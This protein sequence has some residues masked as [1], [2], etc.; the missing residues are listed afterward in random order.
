MNQQ[1]QP[2][3]PKGQPSTAQPPANLPGVD[4]DV[5]PVNNLQEPLQQEP[6]QT[7]PAQQPVQQQPVQKDPIQKQPVQQKSAQPVQPEPVQNESANVPERN[8]QNQG[9]FPEK[10]TKKISQDPGVNKFG[11]PEDLIPKSLPATKEVESNNTKQE[12]PANVQELEKPKEEQLTRDTTREKKSELKENEY[13]GPSIENLEKKSLI[14]KVIVLVIAGILLVLGSIFAYN[15]WIKKPVTNDNTP[16]EV[17]E[18][19]PIVEE[20]IDEDGLPNEWEIKYGLNPQDARDGEQDPDFDRLTNKKEYEYGTDPKKADTDSDGFKDGE[21]VQGGFNP[22]GSGKLNDNNS[23]ANYYPTIKGKWQGTMTGAVYGSEIFETTLQSNGNVAGNLEYKI[24]NTDDKSLACE[25]EGVF[26][27][28]K[29]KSTFNSKVSSNA[30]YKEGK[31]ILTRGD[32]NISLMGTLKDGQK[33][34]SGTWVLEPVTNIFWLKQD[35][36]NFILRK[37]SDF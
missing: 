20:D 5:N 19:D 28:Q 24:L 33:E 3:Q 17:I 16:V 1:G 37:I 15:K 23:Q 10:A 9:G 34:L 25:L 32:L 14:K 26:T 7:E 8:V 29:E 21:E 18:L 6:T 13:A 31:A 35:R 2:N 30:G 11:E 12:E 22:N 27:F 36:G 4:D